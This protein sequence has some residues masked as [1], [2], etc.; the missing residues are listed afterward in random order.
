MLKD[1]AERIKSLEVQGATNVA[2]ESLKAVKEYS[3]KNNIKKIRSGIDLLIST[4]PTEPLMINMLNLLKEIEDPTEVGIKAQD[5]IDTIHNGMEKIVEIGSR[6]IKDGMV[7]QTICHSMT[8]I[9]ILERAKKEGKNI[10]VVATETRPR[11]QGQKTA[12][13]LKKLKIPVKFYVDSGMYVAMKKENVDLCL[14]GIDALFAN[15][16]IANKIGT[17]LLALVAESLEV[18]LYACGLGLKFDKGSLMAQSVEIEKRDPKEIWNYS[19]EV[20][21]PAFE[22]VP[23]S[24][25]QGIVTEIGLLPPATAYLEIERVYNL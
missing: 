9:R 11:Y 1:V 15:G 6:L 21:N 10:T 5:F 7:V 18:P 22:I 2:M 19:V 23:N 17:G 24:R 25:I 4:R 3:K 12:K 14:V 13:E 16:S 8:V 20:I